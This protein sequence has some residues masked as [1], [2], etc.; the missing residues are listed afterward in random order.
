M[1][2]GRSIGFHKQIGEIIWIVYERIGYQSL[3]HQSSRLLG[4]R[5]IQD[6]HLG[7]HYNRTPHRQ[8]LT[9][10]LLLPWHRLQSSALLSATEPHNKPHI[11]GT[12]SALSCGSRP[13]S[14]S[15][16]LAIARNR[17]RS[18]ATAQ[19]PHREIAGAIARLK[20]APRPVRPAATSPRAATPFSQLNSII[21]KHRARAHK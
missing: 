1:G 21:C 15:E 13:R 4:F 2:R 18:A 8:R 14:L 12:F 19:T 6:H 11:S 5:N 3:N 20:N 10:F 7:P 16:H 17:M 9:L